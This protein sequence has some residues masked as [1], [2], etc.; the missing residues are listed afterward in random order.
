LGSTGADLITVL[1]EL[2]DYAELALT[3][4]GLEPDAIRNWQDTLGVAA[5]RLETAW[6]ALEGVVENEVAQRMK[7][8]DQV[9]K[10]RRPV[11]PVLTLAVAAVPAA[12]WFGL[13]LGGFLTAPGWLTSIWRLVF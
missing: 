12:A 9:S 8:A 11:W 10:W 7:T 5:R 3:A 6:L 4:T 2:E 1:D 13:V